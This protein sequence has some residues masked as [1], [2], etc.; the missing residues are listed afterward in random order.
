ML[1]SLLPRP[2]LRLGPYPQR[3][4]TYM[5]EFETAAM[6]IFRKIRHWLIGNRLDLGKILEKIHAYQAPLQ[7][8]SDELLT[9]S[10]S[11]LKEKLYLGGLKEDL[12]IEAF[13]LIREVADREIGK[14]HFDNQLICGWLM[15]N[16]KLVEMATGEGKTLATAL[17]ACTAAMAGIPVHVIT[18]NDYLAKRDAENLQPLYQR[19]G[20]LA[21]SVTDGMPTEQRRENYQANIVYTTNKQIAFDYL[22]DRIQMGDDTGQLMIN[23]RRTQQDIEQGGPSAFLLRGLCFALIDEADSILIDEAKTPLII[24]KTKSDQPDERTYLDALHLAELL[25]EGED[26]VA[27]V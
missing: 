10:I 18:A 17:A 12:V 9:I 11:A 8:S 7:K 15:L 27:D 13:A 20:M 22:R 5:T 2:G 23:F 1:D 21:T 24:T 19:F 6:H 16:G 25:I 4:D 14:R 26:F 3:V